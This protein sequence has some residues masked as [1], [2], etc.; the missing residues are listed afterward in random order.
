MVVFYKELIVL[1]VGALDAVHE[2]PKANLYLAKY[3]GQTAKSSAALSLTFYSKA[4]VSLEAK[5]S[6]ATP[7]ELADIQMD[8]GRLYECGRGVPSDLSKAKLWY[9]KAVESGKGG[10]TEYQAA[11]DRVKAAEKGN[12]KSV[13]CD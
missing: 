13:S 3:Y 2:S 8:L 1:G 11:L 7:E 5:L 9:S 4:L 10:S 6:K 12:V